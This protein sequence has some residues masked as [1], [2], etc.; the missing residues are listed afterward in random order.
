MPNTVP[1]DSDP[2][3]TTTSATDFLQLLKNLVVAGTLNAY[4]QSVALGLMRNVEADQRWGVG[5]LAD[6]GTT[7][8]NKNG[9]LSVDNSN[10]SGEDDNGRWIVSSVGIVNVHGQQ[11]LVSIF[12]E[13][14]PSMQA[15]VNLVQQ[16]AQ[17]VTP[18]VTATGR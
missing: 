14:Q 18:A 2:T 8:A 4:S 13:H 16:L 11:L 3:F 15:G 5:V 10:G 17:V 1:G 7:F 12:T 6:P 9:W